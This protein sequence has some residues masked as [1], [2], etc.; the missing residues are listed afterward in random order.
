MKRLFFLLCC[1]PNLAFAQQVMT[2][3]QFT[4]EFAKSVTKS[5]PSTK[6]MVKNEL[7]LALTNPAGK[8][9]SVFL[10]NAY[11][12]YLLLPTDIENVT[13]RYTVSAL[14]PRDEDAKIDRARIVPIIKDR[15]WLSEI[16]ESMKERGAKKPLEN[17]FE[18]FNDQLAIV[19]AED[20]PKSIRYFTW[21]SLEEIGVSRTQLRGLAISNLRRILPK[22]EI[23]KGPVVSMVTAGGNFE[24]CLLLL[25]EL[26]T[27][28]RIQV[29]GDIVVAIP[30]R[31]LLLV[32]GS[33]SPEG[34]AK[35]REIIGKSQQ[36]SAYRITDALFIFRNGKFEKFGSAQ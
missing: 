32:T 27:D 20:G 9:S 1:L 22:I 13:Q 35:L 31:D 15:Q 34:I 23:H 16:G 5:S 30:S 11:K 7:E 33:R 19:Y 2:P 18:E 14:E 24:A 10:D 29:D 36:T 4:A 8:A 3:S 26:W 21:K 17:A 12:E 25:N 28:G 6:V